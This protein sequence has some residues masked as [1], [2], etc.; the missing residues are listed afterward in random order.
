MESMTH[1]PIQEIDVNCDLFHIMIT[2]ASKSSPLNKSH[3]IQIGEHTLRALQSVEEIRSLLYGMYSRPLPRSEPVPINVLPRTAKGGKLVCKP[4]TLPHLDDVNFPSCKKVF[5][6][7][8]IVDMATDDHGIGEQFTCEHIHH[9][10]TKYA[11]IYCYGNLRG[12]KAY[13]KYL[14]ERCKIV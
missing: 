8:N 1:N 6:E 12:N 5:K 10:F 4:S 7:R 2:R 13:T 9:L 3:S 11:N 14:E